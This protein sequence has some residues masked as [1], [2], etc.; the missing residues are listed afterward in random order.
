MRSAD[1]D[2][3]HDWKDARNRYRNLLSI[4][5]AMQGGT[6][7]ARDAGDLTASGLKTAVQQMDRAGYALSG[8]RFHF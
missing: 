8:R 3:A 1:A 2:L 6:Q 5:K 4:D 7:A